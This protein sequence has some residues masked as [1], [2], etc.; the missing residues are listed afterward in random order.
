[1][2]NSQTLNAIRKR[3]AKA[4]PGTWKTGREF[5][6][7]SLGSHVA[8]LSGKLPPVELDPDRN[9]RND[10]AF[11]AHARQDIPAL[12]AEIDRLR[13]IE[14]AALDYYRSGGDV[15]DHNAL[16]D[17]VRADLEQ[18]DTRPSRPEELVHGL[19]KGGQSWCTGH[20]VRASLKP[21]TVTCT[22]CLTAMDN[23]PNATEATR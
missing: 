9:G 19:R 21:D 7:G 10:A 5:G 15:D 3:A 17:A 8:V 1:V 6:S 23:A 20:H 18:R 2:L 11:I 14:D 4:T 22:D 12:L 16:M 13:N